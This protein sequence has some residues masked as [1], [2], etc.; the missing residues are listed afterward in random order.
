MIVEIKDSEQKAKIAS[1]I[2]SDLPE[3][4]GIPKHTKN[5]I[6]TSKDLPFFAAYVDKQPI[7]FIVLKSTSDF[8]AEIYCMGVLKAHQHQGFGRLLLK[9]FE[10]YARKHG[11]KLI[12]VKTVEQ[13]KYEEYDATNA[14]YRSMGFYEVEVFPS[15]WDEWNPCQLFIKTIDTNQARQKFY[16]EED[17]C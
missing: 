6:E 1:A 14:F 2:L 10:S 13:G 15:L 9:R 4:F 5:Y 11:Y 3:W 7:G 12:Q 16:E 17:L 8:T